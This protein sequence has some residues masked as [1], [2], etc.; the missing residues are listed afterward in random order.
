M[1]KALCKLG[2]AV[3]SCNLSILEAEGRGSEV[4][5]HLYLH[6]KFKASLLFVET[7]FLFVCGGNLCFFKAHRFF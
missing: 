1:H 4:Q 3:L 5:V 7:L 6:I 2:V